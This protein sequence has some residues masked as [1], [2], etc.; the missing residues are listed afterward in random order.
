[1]ATDEIDIDD[2]ERGGQAAVGRFTVEAHVEGVSEDY[3]EALAVRLAAMGMT[4][5]IRRVGKDE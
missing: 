3:A 1:M 4:V 5:W 2:N